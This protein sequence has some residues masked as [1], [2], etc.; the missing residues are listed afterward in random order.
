MFSTFIGH[1]D[2]S[3]IFDLPVLDNN[4][5]WQNDVSYKPKLQKSSHL[6]SNNTKNYWKNLMN[7]FEW[8][9]LL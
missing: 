4:Q 7:N 6:L 8:F 3:M 9:E 5:F 1:N 2:S